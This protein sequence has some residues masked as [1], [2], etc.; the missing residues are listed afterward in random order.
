MTDPVHSP[1]IAG[2]RNAT[3]DWQPTKRYS[4]AQSVCAQTRFPTRNRQPNLPRSP[5]DHDRH[6]A[7]HCGCEVLLPRTFPEGEV[8]LVDHD[9]HV[10]SVY[11]GAIPQP[12][13]E[14]HVHRTVPIPMR[15]P[16][17]QQAAWSGTPIQLLSGSQ[18]VCRCDHAQRAMDYNTFGLR[19]RASIAGTPDVHFIAASR[20]CMRQLKSI[21]AYP[22]RLWRIFAGEDGPGNSLQ[23]D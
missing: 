1:S 14:R 16:L 19:S 17:H 9:L 10:V 11:A 12:E 2:Y 8:R 15:N 22:A 6:E 23:T 21:V 13:A 7:M 5:E 4:S 18:Q 3:G 20:Q